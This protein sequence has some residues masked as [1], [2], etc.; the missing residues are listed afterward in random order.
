MVF[1]AVRIGTTKRFR[2]VEIAG[3]TGTIADIKGWA[4]ICYP[5]ATIKKVGR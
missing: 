1:T 4:R 3:V 5:G 2:L